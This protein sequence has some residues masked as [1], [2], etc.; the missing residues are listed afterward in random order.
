MTDP[1]KWSAVDRLIRRWVKEKAI[2]GAVVDISLGAD[3]RWSQA[4]G[5]Y[6]DG[7]A[8]CQITERTMF[9]V[10][11]LTKVTVT[12]PVILALAE[13][14]RLRLDDPV[15]AYIPAFRHPNVTLRHLLMHTSGLSP[16]LP[17]AKRTERRDVI[18]LVLKQELVT[19]PGEQAV[20]S[21]LGMILLGEVAAVVSGQSLE[22]CA[23]RYVFDPLGMAD[24]MFNPRPELL[25][26]IAA[27]EPLDDGTG[28]VHGV[29]HDEKSYHLGGVSGSAGLFT[30]ADDLR[31]YARAWLDPSGGGLLSRETINACFRNPY[32]GRALGW[33]IW[34]GQERAPS[35]GASW[36][37][38][39]FGHTG[40]TGTSLWIDPFH[41]LIVVFLTN[42]VHFGRSPIM[43]ELRPILHTTVYTSLIEDK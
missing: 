43:R 22:S 18:P 33:E 26:R 29:V 36:P 12:L 32:Q 10:A 11:S 30:T 13:Q 37:H 3:V 19:E 35:C 42:A 25:G 38:G 28:Y 24:S 7:T 41:E 21:D 31:K 14:G 9:D 34:H 4:Y 39:S 40:F 16:E 17:Y 8:E 5:S 2:P 15:Q 1:K 20:Y 23:R 6:S 27:T